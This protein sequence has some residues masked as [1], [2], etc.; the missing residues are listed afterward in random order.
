MDDQG[1]RS[2]QI[3]LVNNFAILQPRRKQDDRISVAFKLNTNRDLT[4]LPGVKK[5]KW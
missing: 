2:P 5:T 4:Q 3:F 1:Q